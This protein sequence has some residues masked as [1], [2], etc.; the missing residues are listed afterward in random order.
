MPDTNRVDQIMDDIEQRRLGPDDTFRFKCYGCGKCC[1][2][3]T[4]ILLNAQD[5]FRMSRHLRLEPKQLLERYCETYIGGQSI[6]PL[7]RLLPRGK[8]NACPLL[9]DNRCLVHSAKPTVCALFPLGRFMSKSPDNPDAP[10]EPGYFLQQITCGGHKSNTVRGYLESFGLSVEDGF[11]AKW[12]DILVYLT[13]YCQEA[14]RK[15]VSEGAMERLWG[16]MHHFL[17]T[18]YDLEADFQ[19]QLEA[20]FF[21]LRSLLEEIKAATFASPLF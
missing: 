14:I 18:A 10:P 12:S 17:Y 16:I 15:C 13:G 19:P 6:I 11:F 8:F 21:S 2:N 9:K 20:N 7:V 4:N 3:R 5:V 1:K